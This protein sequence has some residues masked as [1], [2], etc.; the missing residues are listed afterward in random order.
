MWKTGAPPCGSSLPEAPADASREAE[1]CKVMLD[2]EIL[3]Q[4]LCYSRNEEL[5]QVLTA[6]AEKYNLCLGGNSL[7][8]EGTAGPGWRAVRDHGRTWVCRSEGNGPGVEGEGRREGRIKD[9]LL[10]WEH[11]PGT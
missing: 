9:S 3:I 2:L 8:T 11:S 10:S 6:R 7:D 4:Y 5:G 1:A